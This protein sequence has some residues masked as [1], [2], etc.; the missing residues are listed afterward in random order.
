MSRKK[1]H[2]LI[3]WKSEKKNITQLNA[4]Y[5]KHEILNTQL[6]T[7]IKISSTEMTI[8]FTWLKCMLKR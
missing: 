3:L 4:A 1:I 6:N 8:P 7:M 5:R 2:I